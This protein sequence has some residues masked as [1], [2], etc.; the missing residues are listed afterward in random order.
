MKV[1]ASISPGKGQAVGRHR[2]VYTAWAAAAWSGSFGFVH[3]YWGLGGRIGLG[4]SGTADVAF[5]RAWF[6]WFNMIAGV[7]CLLAAVL[8]LAI[9]RGWGRFPSDR[10]LRGG[11]WT[12]TALLLTRG[13]LGIGQLVLS[14]RTEAE[15]VSPVLALYDPWFVLG[16][17]LF[18]LLAWRTRRGGRAPSTR[19]RVGNRN[20]VA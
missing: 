6:A 7:A 12:A 19:S 13:V 3:F 9:A 8:A 1:S 17:L 18:G 2:G 5:E 16:G 14:Q 10:L 4:D 11:L 15:E 20:P